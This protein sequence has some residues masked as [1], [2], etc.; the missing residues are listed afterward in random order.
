MGSCAK[1][2][3]S[4]LDR[5]KKGLVVLRLMVMLKLGNK[6]FMPRCFASYGNCVVTAQG[7]PIPLGARHPISIVRER[8]IDVF[9]QLTQTLECGTDEA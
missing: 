9:S 4:G 2:F 8:V 1:A 6:T 3:K 7:Q 5:K